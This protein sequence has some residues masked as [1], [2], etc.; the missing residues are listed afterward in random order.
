MT[1][2]VG[3]GIAGFGFAGRMMAH[4][5]YRSHRFRLAAVAD[6]DA[7]RREEARRAGAPRLY[8]DLDQLLHDDA[9]EV[10][11]LATPTSLHA[12]GVEQAA[13]AG[14]HVIVEK[15]F[16]ATPA[17]ARLAVDASASANVALIVGATRSF[18]A[19]IRHLQEMI[20]RGVLGQLQTITSLCSTDWLVRPRT[21]DDLDGELGG[22]I[23]YRQGCHQLDVL[24]CLAG[25][26]ARSVR[27]STFGGSNGT[28]RGYSALIFFESGVTGTAVYQGWGGFDSRL[29]TFGRGE[30]G[31]LVALP[32]DDRRRAF[33]PSVDP[34]GAPVGTA[35]PAF[36]FMLATFLEFDVVPSPRGWLVIG[37]SG[38]EE[39]AVDPWPSGWD[40]VLF[41]LERV[42]DGQPSIHDGTS[43]LATLELCAAVHRSA[44]TGTEVVP[45]TGPLQTA[46][47]LP[48]PP[49]RSQ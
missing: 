15:P 46:R 12:S 32:S 38:A 22:G 10:I 42:L 33:L 40:A 8:T 39:V 13:K 1:G 28:E 36:G 4:A 21:P 25:S 23:V 35:P 49:R 19:P 29:L 18:D 48:S 20:V 34:A 14:R 30:L 11:Y 43:A 26:S 31:E 6:P 2:T 47:R 41:E 44:R 5:L 3:L 9:L 16:A 45:G 17:E 27:A 37:R 7:S 24:R